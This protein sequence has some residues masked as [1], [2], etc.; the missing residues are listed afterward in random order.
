MLAVT[1]QFGLSVDAG[2]VEVG[3]VL[4]NEVEHLN[5]YCSKKS[6]KSN[7]LF[8]YREEGIGIICLFFFFLLFYSAQH[9][10]ASFLPHYP[11]S[12]FVVYVSLFSRH[13]VHT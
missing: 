3:A 12:L 8:H 10:L 6:P 5:S 2:D 13:E 9:L 7:L 4:L 11:H 1:C